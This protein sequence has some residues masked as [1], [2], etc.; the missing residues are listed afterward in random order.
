MRMTDKLDVSCYST[1]ELVL[2]FHTNLYDHR[3]FYLFI[4]KQNYLNH[5]E[6]YFKKSLAISIV[7]GPTK[8]F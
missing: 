6:N 2:K 8:N 1:Y 3:S 7:M 4:L 5:A